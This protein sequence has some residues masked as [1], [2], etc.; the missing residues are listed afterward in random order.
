MIDIWT[1]G[2]LELTRSVKKNGDHRS[3]QVNNF[4]INKSPSISQV[5]IKRKEGGNSKWEI[6]IVIEISK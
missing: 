5:I 1:E 4:P 6:R 3:G 2:S